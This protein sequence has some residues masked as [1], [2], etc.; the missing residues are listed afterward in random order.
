MEN[1]TCGDLGLG[2]LQQKR[3]SKQMKKGKNKEDNMIKRTGIVHSTKSGSLTALGC[4]MT[5]YWAPKNGPG[6][7]GFEDR[8]P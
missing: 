5:Q 1:M 4:H 2:A 6:L 8:E 3:K 7:L